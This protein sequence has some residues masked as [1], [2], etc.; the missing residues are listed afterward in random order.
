MVARDHRRQRQRGGIL[1]C[2]DWKEQL[3][4]VGSGETYPSSPTP[5]P[6]ALGGVTHDPNL[7]PLE[8]AG[9]R[10]VDGLALGHTARA[11]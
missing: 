9:L 8:D 11:W 6:G 10:E 7:H 1:A 5:I 3:T 4:L 2:L